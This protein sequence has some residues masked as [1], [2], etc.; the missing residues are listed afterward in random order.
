MLSLFFLSFNSL[1]PNTQSGLQR[2]PYSLMVL[3]TF[4]P[5]SKHHARP[6]FAY[7]HQSSSTAIKDPK[8]QYRSEAQSC[9]TPKRKEN[10]KQRDAMRYCPMRQYQ[11]PP[12]WT[13]L[14]LALP[15]E[16]LCVSN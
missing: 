8:R 1:L 3:E 4:E 13:S 10:E 14:P 5:T 7:V 6:I 12:P 11:V 15:R 9:W 2:L 16:L